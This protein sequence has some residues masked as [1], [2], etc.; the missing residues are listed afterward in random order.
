MIETID[1]TDREQWLAMRRRDVTASVAACL[2]GPDVHEYQTA[3]GLYML[4]TGALSEDPEETAP[5]Q[6]G[7]LLEPVAVSL[8]REKHPD[9]LVTQPNVYLRDPEARLGATPDAYATLPDHQTGVVQIK[10]VEPSIF[11]KKWRDPDTGETRP[12]LWIAVQA[13]VEAH[14]AR[15]DF[16][17]VAALVVGHGLDLHE[18]PVPIHPGIVERTRAE[19]ARF[20]AMVAE[21]TPPDPEYG[22]DAQ[23]IARLFDQDDGTEIDLSNDNRLPEIVIRRAELKAV[24][25]T[26]EEAAKERKALD[27]EIIAKLGNA[28]RGRLQDGTIITA[29][30]VRRAGYEVKPSAYR[31]VRIP[32]AA[33]NRLIPT[34]VIPERF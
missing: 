7:R 25:K 18:V 9:W 28:S 13:I 23:T 20:W 33:P 17:M 15:A 34:T 30:T 27:A 6:R 19:V 2:F 32:D 11:R 26:G 5:M 24:E 8:L 29:K 31:V 14:L 1:I 22:K 21:G 12:P 4:K 16:A 10:S 3:F